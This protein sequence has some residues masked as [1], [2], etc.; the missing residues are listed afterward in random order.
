MEQRLLYNGRGSKT[1][2]DR[3]ISKNKN[4]I[5]WCN[6]ESAENGT[7]QEQNRENKQSLP[8]EK[9]NGEKN[10]RKEK[11]YLVIHNT[12]KINNDKTPEQNSA[13]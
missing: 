10:L 4:N 6:E 5:G 2:F 9:K 8:R 1:L 3:D 12:S 11:K 13:K 7:R